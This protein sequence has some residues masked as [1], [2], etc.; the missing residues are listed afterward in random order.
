M[1][2]F[3]PEFAGQIADPRKEQ[4]TIRDM[5][6]M[7]AGYPY[8]STGHYS[9]VLYLSGNW[10]W[11]P[12]L[13]GFP[14]VSDPGTEVNYS[15]VTSHLLGVI[16]ARACDT[17]LMSFAQEHLFTPIDAELG[18]W[19]RDLDG[20]NWGWGEIFVTARDMARFGLLYLNDGDYEGNQ[21]ISADWVHDS[22][23][24]YS[25]DAWTSTSIGPTSATRGM[26]I[27]GGPP[28]QATIASTLRGDMVD[29]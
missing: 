18:D 20:Y 24:T 25:E 10:R 15:S 13:V 17:D 2:D 4:I 14:L 23:Q 6:Q 9:D 28:G 27:S 11:L 5:L 1:M 8:D 19:T 3:F 26:A 12:H 22:L 7:R 21:V 16:M 29:N